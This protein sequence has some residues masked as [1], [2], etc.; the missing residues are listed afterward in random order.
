MAEVI[1]RQPITTEDGVQSQASP[2][3]VVDKMALSHAFL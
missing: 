3:F 2:G 1:S